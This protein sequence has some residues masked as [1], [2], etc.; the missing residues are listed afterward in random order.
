M[1]Q[2][3][4]PLKAQKVHSFMNMLTL[5]FSNSYNKFQRCEKICGLKERFSLKKIKS[6][7]GGKI[8]LFDIM[9]RSIIKFFCEKETISKISFT[10]TKLEGTLA[11]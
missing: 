7:S 2:V 8:L 5:A 6:K 3:G 4:A 1:S 10:R 9:M 11:F